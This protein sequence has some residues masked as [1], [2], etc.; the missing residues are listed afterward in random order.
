MILLLS[1]RFAIYILIRN[2]IRYI[3]NLIDLKSFCKFDNNIHLS[4]YEP[5]LY[6]Y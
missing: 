6:N 4:N 3:D 2:I 5:N 1:I